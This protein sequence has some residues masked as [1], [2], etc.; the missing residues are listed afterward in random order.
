MTRPLRLEFAG[1][2]YHVTSRGDRKG[3]I[4]RDEADRR[5]WLE[6]LDRVC[7]RFNFVVHCYCQMGNHFHLL[8]ETVEGN[9]S[10]GMR[11]LNGLYTQHF[12]RHHKLVGH[13]FQGRYQSILVQ[14]ESYLLELTR[15]VVLNPL[16]ANVVRRLEDWPWSSH[17][18][19]MGEADA[20]QWLD[21]NWLLGHFGTTQGLAAPKY[22][23]FV[24]AGL[25]C[26]SPLKQVSHQ[27]ILGDN[28]FVEFHH[29]LM[30]KASLRDVSKAQRRAV[31][32]PLAEYRS[33]FLLRD[34]AMARAYH[35]TA[36]TMAQIGDY[37]GVSPTTVARAVQRF[38]QTP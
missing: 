21:T 37:F 31:A 28:R 16:R 20:P 6:T 26:K 27:L 25:G 38:E 34:E 15:Y 18:F 24:M 4:Y 11:Q 22:Y 17:R 3:V 32:L 7:Q 23:D 30:G 33:Q 36:F 8:L 9:L 2:L 10:Q 12:N 13:L 5:A 19:F 14:K 35:S 1:A 29:N